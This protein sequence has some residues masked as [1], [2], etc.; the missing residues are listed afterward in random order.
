MLKLKKKKKKTILKAAMNIV[1]LVLAIKIHEDLV[2]SFLGVSAIGNIS[3]SF[4]SVL[5]E[6]SKIKFGE[7]G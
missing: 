7:K 2:K 3:I 1:Y 5:K 4:K 6:S